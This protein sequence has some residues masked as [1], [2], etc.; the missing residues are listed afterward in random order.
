MATRRRWLQFSLRSFLVA[1]TIGCIWL[2]WNVER[3]SKQRKAVEAVEAIGGIVLYDWQPSIDSWETLP[4]QSKYSRW[5]ASPGYR[6]V[7]DGAKP[8]ARAWLRNLLGEHLFQNATSVIFRTRQAS[9]SWDNKHKLLSIGA[10]HP[11]APR[12]NEIEVVAPRLHGLPA[13][14][15]I[16]LQ[17]DE[18]AIS[19][20]VE[21][22]LRLAFPQCR[23]IRESVVTAV[24]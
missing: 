10:F 23:I 11:D 7:P 8:S 13:L 4:E 3:A 12:T 5:G 21:E 14:H 19:K 15:A 9:Y 24:K 2:G 6:L 1:L 16:Y 18:K 22:K 20:A 17:G